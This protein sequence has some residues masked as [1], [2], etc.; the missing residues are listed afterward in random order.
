MF[1]C[2]LALFVPTDWNEGL[3]FVYIERCVIGEMEKE[4]TAGGLWHMKLTQ[5]DTAFFENRRAR[6]VHTVTL[7]IDHLPDPTLYNL[8]ATP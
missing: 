8:D 7:I 5:N 3:V 2:I 1:F 6:H 4:G